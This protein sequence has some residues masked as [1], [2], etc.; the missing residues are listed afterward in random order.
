MASKWAQI[1][2]YSLPNIVLFAPQSMAPY[3]QVEILMRAP[4]M[5]LVVHME[6]LSTLQAEVSVTNYISNYTLRSRGLFQNYL[7]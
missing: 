5:L 3:P 6:F 7:A 1:L 2:A 4:T